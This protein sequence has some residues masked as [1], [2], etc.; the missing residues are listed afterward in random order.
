[1]DPHFA[2]TINTPELTSSTAGNL[3]QLGRSVSFF[4]VE[5]LNVSSSKSAST[6]YYIRILFGCGPNVVGSTDGYMAWSF[7]SGNYVIGNYVP[8]L[9]ISVVFSDST[10]S[11]NDVS[12]CES[13]DL[14]VFTDIELV[15]VYTCDCDPVGFCVCDV[16]PFSDFSELTE[17][18]IVCFINTPN[19]RSISNTQLSQLS[20]NLFPFVSKL[21]FWLYT[22]SSIDFMH[23][24]NTPDLAITNTDLHHVS[25]VYQV[26]SCTFEIGI[27]NTMTVV[28]L[29]I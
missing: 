6:K 8:S 17:P 16:R 29:S 1:M 23:V 3:F 12:S 2:F 4:P 24:I 14:T 9:T 13:P 20:T 19:S 18:S 5:S 27:G 26:P 11:I 28:G 25:S 7:Y 15:Q 21:Y 22:S 10:T